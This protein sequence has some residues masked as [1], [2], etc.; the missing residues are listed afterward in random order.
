MVSI[1]GKIIT[2]FC[3]LFLAINAIGKVFEVLSV[4]K[5]EKANPQKKQLTSAGY[6]VFFTAI[7]FMLI[8]KLILSLLSLSTVDFKIAGG[9]LLFL[10]AAYHLLDKNEPLIFK[11]S[12]V[13]P[14]ISQLIIR[15]AFLIMLLV[16]ICQYGFIITLLALLLNLVVTYHVF[17]NSAKLLGIIEE[18]GVKIVSKALSIL[19]CAYAVMLLREGLIA[20]FSL[21]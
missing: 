6:F 12:K 10:L 4:A 9:I 14:L 5:V 19:L 18:S 21:L 1:L 8:S 3:A 11:E 15:P 2:S 20:G 16:L 13:F 17:K 7:S